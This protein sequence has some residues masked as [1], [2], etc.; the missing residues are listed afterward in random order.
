MAI[1]TV[2]TG[3]S[4]PKEEY[5]QLEKIRRKMR[6]SRSALFE[7]ALSFWLKSLRE[8]GKIKQYIEGYKKYPESVTEIKAMEKASAEAFSA[9]GLK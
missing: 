6:L 4:L 2:K 1:G 8:Q 5:Q 3:I 7:K 9:E